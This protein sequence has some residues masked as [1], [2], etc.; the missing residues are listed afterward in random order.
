M[1]EAFM[2]TSVIPG[3]SF[4][5]ISNHIGVATCGESHAN[6]RT[7]SGSDDPLGAVLAENM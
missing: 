3:G 2:G 5:H 1:P 6:W 4:P 7:L